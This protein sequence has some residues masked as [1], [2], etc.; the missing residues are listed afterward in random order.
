MNEYFINCD[1]CG[2]YVFGNRLCEECSK[3]E[4]KKEDYLI[5]IYKT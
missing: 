3:E 1:K 2:K 4:L 5:D